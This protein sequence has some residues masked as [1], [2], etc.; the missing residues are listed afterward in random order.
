MLQYDCSSELGFRILSDQKTVIGVQ[1]RSKLRV[2]KEDILDESHPVVFYKAANSPVSVLILD[3]SAGLLLTGEGNG[4][5]GRVIQ[6]DLLSGRVLRD[7][8]SLG[9]GA[10]SSGARSGN[11]CFFGGWGS[12]SF[13]A[14]DTV[15]Q[16]RV[17]GPVRTA[18][19]N[20]LSLQICTLV[21]DSA[22]AKKVLVV[23]GDDSD[24]SQNSPDMLDVTNLI[25]KFTDYDSLRRLAM[26]LHSQKKLIES[27]IK[28]SEQKKNGLLNKLEKQAEQVK[29][30][31]LLARQNVV[32]GL[33]AQRPFDKE[34]SGSDRGS[35]DSKNESSN[36]GLDRKWAATLRRQQLKRESKNDQDPKPQ[37]IKFQLDTAQMQDRELRDLVPYLQSQNYRLASKIHVGT[38]QTPESQVDPD[39]S[40]DRCF[41][42]QYAS[43]WQIFV[44]LIKIKCTFLR[45]FYAI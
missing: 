21:T 14:I 24:Y 33:I 45:I 4:S 16:R 34:F 37:D 10:V 22:R 44:W 31:R 32:L 28:S 40:F 1:R 13:A 7:Y 30:N 3:Q 26:S 19:Q 2:A 18:V 5:N 36:Y 35:D 6:Y 12:S 27:E 43:I 20:L 9:M 23:S 41:Y 11:L 42:F 15:R 17:L 38:D 8:A 29:S 39:S 25:E